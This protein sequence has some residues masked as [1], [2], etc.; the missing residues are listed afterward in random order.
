MEVNLVTELN[1]PRVCCTTN[2]FQASVMGSKAVTLRLQ[3][4]RAVAPMLDLSSALQ[5]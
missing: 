2:V 1:L 3:Q 4:V 5:R